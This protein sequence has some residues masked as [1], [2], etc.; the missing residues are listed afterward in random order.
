MKPGQV[1]PPFSPSRALERAPLASP[2]SPHTPQTFTI[3]PMI[4]VGQQKDMHWPDKVRL[5]FSSLSS[6]LLGP[7]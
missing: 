3:E 1:R 4:C 6:L 2:D 5:A 7:G